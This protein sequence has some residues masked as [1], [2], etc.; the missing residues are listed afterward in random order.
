MHGSIILEITQTVTDARCEYNRNYFYF[1][2]VQEKR[3]GKQKV[4]T[5]INRP[6]RLE[7][8]KKKKHLHDRHWELNA[9]AVVAEL[10]EFPLLPLWLGG[11]RPGD[12]SDGPR[13][14]RIIEKN[15]WDSHPTYLTCYKSENT[16]TSVRLSMP[17]GF[18]RCGTSK[19]LKD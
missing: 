3:R 1:A 5:E 15:H 4:W 10:L 11:P 18:M 2:F 13:P 6:K 17:T 9:E 19:C 14:V 16:L 8:W 12:D 7:F